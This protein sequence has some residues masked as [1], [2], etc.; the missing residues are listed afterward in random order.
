MTLRE[1]LGRGAN[2]GECLRGIRQQKGLLTRGSQAGKEAS[3]VED[4]V[5]QPSRSQLIRLR[6]VSA[7]PKKKPLTARGV[8]GLRLQGRV[9]LSRVMPPTLLRSRRFNPVDRT[10]GPSA[11]AEDLPLREELL[12]TLLPLGLR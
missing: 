9:T 8:R 7:W 10:A 3:G 4:R 2:T 1:S 12:R 5:E 11:Y 6:L